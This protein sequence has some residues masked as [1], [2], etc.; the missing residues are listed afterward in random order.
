MQHDSWGEGIWKV[1]CLKFFLLHGVFPTQGSNSCLQGLL[2]CRWI[3][4]LLSHWGSPISLFIY[5]FIFLYLHLKCLCVWERVSAYVWACA[6]DPSYF[7]TG[8]MYNPGSLNNCLKLFL[9]NAEQL[10]LIS[11]NRFCHSLWTVRGN[12]FWIRLI[13]AYISLHTVHFVFFIFLWTQEINSF[14]SLLVV[15]NTAAAATTT[16]EGVGRLRCST[17]QQNAR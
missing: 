17:L 3:V 7:I 8:Q 9:V 11:G 5:L 15:A 4:Y 16:M 10:L 6:E 12:A 1:R 14:S 13:F 2:H